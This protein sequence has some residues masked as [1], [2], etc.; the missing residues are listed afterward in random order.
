MEDNTN[1][2]TKIKKEREKDESTVFSTSLVFDKNITKIWLFI[3]DFQNETRSID[4]FDNLQYIKGDN[5]WTKGNIFT[6]NWLGLTRVKLQCINVM[7]D[8]N[9]NIIKWKVKG[10]I[11]LNYYKTI[12]FYRITNDDKTLVKTNIT[13][14]RD[15][16]DCIDYIASKN[17]YSNLDYNILL[18]KSKFVNSL[19]EDVISYESCVVHQSLENIWHNLTDLKKINQISFIIGRKLEIKDQQLREGSFLKFI[20]EYLNIYI[21]MKIV[22]AKIY[23]KK[24]YGIIRLDTIGVKYNEIIKRIEY[25]IIKINENKTQFSILNILPPDINSDFMNQF[26]IYKKENIKKFKLFFEE[27]ENNE[28]LEK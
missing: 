2:N 9:K 19:K 14:E 20:L 15:N 17:Y 11:G 12:Y 27:N 28:I 23:K 5:T 8:R 10:D 6:M 25:K 3:R 26:Q 4:F 16:N 22:E 21:F 7:Q 24:K 18:T 13:I 1:I